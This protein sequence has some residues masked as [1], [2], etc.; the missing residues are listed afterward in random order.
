MKVLDNIVFRLQKAGGISKYWAETTKRI[1][2]ND[3]NILF[4]ESIAAKSN[5]FRSELNYKH[6]IMIDSGSTWISRLRSPKISAEVFHSSYYR[7]SA[8][9][10]S[11]VV[12]IHDFMNEKFVRSYRDIILSRQKKWACKH[13]DIVVTV[14][15]KTRDDLLEFYPF[16]KPKNVHVV[17]NGVD[18]RFYPEKFNKPFSLEGKYLQEREFFLYVGNRGYCKNF[19][20]VLDFLGEAWAQG[21]RHPLILVGGP[22]FSKREWR[23]FNRLGLPSSALLHLQ[24]IGTD[25]LRVLYSNCLALLIP[26]IYEGFGLPAAE[27]ARCGALV[28]A[29]Q[30]SALDEIVGQTNYTFNLNHKNEAL[31]ILKLGLNNHGSDETRD[32]L[33]LKSK[34]FNWDESAKKL[35]RLY[36]SLV[37]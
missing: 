35:G 19:P 26:S 11:N 17:Y 16:V 20:F 31:R 37:P 3:S 5:L 27:A 21:L 1:D 2:K 14:S 32:N 33:R 12:T 9:A 15:K 34:A 25:V 18:E 4:Y 6:S 13:A 30:G 23:T 10:K 7:V 24:S 22:S 36:E 8:L 29:S 28:L